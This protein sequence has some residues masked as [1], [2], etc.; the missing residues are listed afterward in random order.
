MLCLFTKYVVS[1]VTTSSNSLQVALF[2]A[3]AHNTFLSRPSL[4]KSIAKKKSELSTFIFMKYLGFASAS[5][6]TSSERRHLYN[7]ISAI[8]LKIWKLFRSPNLNLK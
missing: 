3:L 7:I 6:S 1:N 8:F 5:P 2:L 4:F